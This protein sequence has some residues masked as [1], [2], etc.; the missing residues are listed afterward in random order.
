MER[1]L[2]FNFGGDLEEAAARKLEANS[3]KTKEKSNIGKGIG[4]LGGALFGLT[5][6]GAGS[7]GPAVWS[8]VGG[9]AGGAAD[10]LLS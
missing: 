10:E 5:P 1:P 7:G 6:W 3:K 2:K 8:S 4:T 9:A